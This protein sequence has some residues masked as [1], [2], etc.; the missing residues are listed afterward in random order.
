MCLNDWLARRTQ[1]TPDLVT[2]LDTLNGGRRI[3]YAEWSRSA[4]RA[5]YFLGRG[6]NVRL[7]DRVACY[8]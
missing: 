4:D 8:P 7:G 5:T 3:T 6:L 2:L 1:L